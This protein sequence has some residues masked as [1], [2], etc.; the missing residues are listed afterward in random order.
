MRK[1]L[2]F[3]A[4]FFASTLIAQDEGAALNEA[5]LKKLFIARHGE[6]MAGY[7]KE[8][9]LSDE[10]AYKGGKKLNARYIMDKNLIY[11]DITFVKIGEIYAYNWV[12]EQG[13]EARPATNN[14]AEAA[15]AY[16]ASIDDRVFAFN[17]N[18]GL[19]A[20]YL[21]IDPF[22]PL[23]ASQL[24]EAIAVK[25]AKFG[26]VFMPLLGEASL[27]K[28]AWLIEQLNE[29]KNDSDRIEFLLK[30][31]EDKSKKEPK[32]DKFIKAL[33]TDLIEY[34]LLKIDT[35]PASVII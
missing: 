22:S 19:K 24:K 6:E 30:A 5:G 15:R 17:I 34:K 33:Q 3:G 31:L 9:R 35:L 12:N 18:R 14:F 13:V 8:I 28:S 25:G 7:I 1:T 16:L 11:P 21:F 4:L 23:C 27:K 10:G 26:F 20:K 2:L 29:I 32:S